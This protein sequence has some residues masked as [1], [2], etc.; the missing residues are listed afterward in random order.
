METHETFT[1]EAESYEEAL[2][3]FENAIEY[4]NLEQYSNN[5]YKLLYEHFHPHNPR[6]LDEN[7]EE[8]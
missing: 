1:I 6:Y 7:Y 4:Y 2:K 3:L 5:D 8:I